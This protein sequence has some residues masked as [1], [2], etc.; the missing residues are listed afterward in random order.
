M[1]SLRVLRILEGVY[2]ESLRAGI[3]SIEFEDGVALYSAAYTLLRG[4]SGALVIDA[5]AGIGYSTLWLAAAMMDA[6]SGPC[7]LVAVEAYT[8]YVDKLRANLERVAR[9][10]GGLVRVEAVAGDALEYVERLP[11]ESID[12]VFVDVDKELYTD[13]LRLLRSRL[14]RGGLAAFHNAYAPPPPPSFY[15]ELRRGWNYTVVPTRL[16]IA[17]AYPRE[18]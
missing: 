18:V 13:M 16:G 11:P 14:K 7:R 10:A 8:P 4:R 17:L 9:E 6:C 3:P 2:E 1:L 15:E 5:G 12:M